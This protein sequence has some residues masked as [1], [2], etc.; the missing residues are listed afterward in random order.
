MTI[1]KSRPVI[2]PS[3]RDGI[4]PPVEVWTLRQLVTFLIGVENDRHAALWWLIA[5]RGLRRGKV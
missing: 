2:G 1:R 3:R 4:R 5:L